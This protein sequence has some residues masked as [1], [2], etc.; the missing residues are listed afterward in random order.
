[1]F[2]PSGKVMVTAVYL[3]KYGCKQQRLENNFK[4]GERLFDGT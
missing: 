3:L 1:M 4:I 2:L